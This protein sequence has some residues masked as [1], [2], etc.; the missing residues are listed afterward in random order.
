MRLF[1]LEGSV[2]KRPGVKTIKRTAGTSIFI[3]SLFISIVRIDEL[4]R[5]SRSSWE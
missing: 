4:F 1:L 5:K 2:N 3:N